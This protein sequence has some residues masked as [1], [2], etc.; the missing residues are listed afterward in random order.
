[1]FPKFFAGSFG[2]LFLPLIV[3]GFI[4][5][6]PLEA[7]AQG[8]ATNDI[9]N[10]G[11]HKI[12]G[13][14]YGASGRRS[15]LMG[16]KIR[17]VNISSNELSVISDGT[18]NFAF[19]N[20]VPGSY[21]VQ[22]DSS[23]TFE[24]VREN[25]TIDDPGSSNLST[26]IRVLG[27][28]KIANVQVFLKP[29][30]SRELR[31]A[32]AV[33]N[34]KLAAI[35]KPAVE[36][37]ESAQRSINEKNDARA[38]DQLR[39]ALSIHNEFSMAW[40]LLGQLLLKTDDAKGAIEAFRYAVKHDSSSAASNLNLGCALFNEKSF[41][42]AEKYLMESLIINPT[43]Y[44]GH[45][46]MGL[47]QLKLARPDVAEQAFRKAIEVGDVQAGMAHYMLAGIY[48]SAKRY[49]EAA[50][51]LEAYLKLEPKAKDAEKAR[52]SI[53]ELRSKQN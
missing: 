31:V 40:N 37:Y 53:A 16:L 29:K 1:M 18:G 27:G 38:I 49:K 6:F 12:Q 25:V 15:D 46:Y 19:K 2:R 47:T 24:E 39:S 21:T 41:T 42:E 44:R 5:V 34:A 43:S 50:T 11:S 22:I 13:R 51:E 9:G 10:G 26:T 20:L 32:L 30:Q 3:L 36:L 8:S 33:I 45:Y 23:E 35:P 28:A 52:A 17:L 48:W 4:S 7:K 14:I